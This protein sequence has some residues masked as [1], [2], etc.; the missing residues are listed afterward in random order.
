[1]N[2][3]DYYFHTISKSSNEEV[4]YVFECILKDGKLKSQKLL[5]HNENKYNGLEYISLARYIKPSKYNVIYLNKKEYNNSKLSSIFNNYN[6]YTNYLKLNN[7][8]EEPIS[9]EEYF[10][11]NNTTNKNDY[12]NYLDS[13][14]R[15]Y[16]VDIKYLFNKTKDNIYK[17]ILDIAKDDILYCNKTEY[18]FLE[19]IKYSKGITF[20]FDN[21]ID[22]VKVN[23]IPNM[24]FEIEKQI[25]KEIQL[26]NKRYS[27]Q[28][29]EVQVK[30]YLD[31][32]SCI[33]IMINNT[34]DISLIREI[35]KKCNYCFK[36]YKI[37]GEKLIE[38]RM[39]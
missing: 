1:M 38:I 8:I 2:I 29:G 35:M 26:S 20:I 18:C 21:S 19:Y 33:G 25:V 36:I 7:Y 6:E 11:L 39:D 9:K 23:I 16:P 34:L 27:N 22:V 4:Y 3:K 15:T 10:K 28:I 30:D 32:S 24:P 14:S 13:I 31:I 17:S 12:Y 37:V 5:N